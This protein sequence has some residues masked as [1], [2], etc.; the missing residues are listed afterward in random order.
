MDLR[1]APST[2]EENIMHDLPTLLV[3]GLSVLVIAACLFI[4][5]SPT[6]ITW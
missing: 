1:R 5:S 2:E 3:I 6:L 4:L